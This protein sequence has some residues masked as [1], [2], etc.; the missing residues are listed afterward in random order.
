M[1]L[2]EF[3]HDLILL[4]ELGF[5][6]C[7]L[8]VL[9]VVSRRPFGGGLKGGGTVLK[10]QL[11]PTVK[12]SGQNLVLVAQVGDRDFVDQVSFDDRDF[13]RRG[14]LTSWFLHHASFWLW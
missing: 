3:G 4:H 9:A 8:T 13:V 5:E 12:L 7:D 1:L 10:E 14:K 11:L 6:L 2:Q